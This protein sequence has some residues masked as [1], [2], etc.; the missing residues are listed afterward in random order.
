MASIAVH[1]QA[2]GQGV[3]QA[4]IEMLLE[5]ELERPLYLMCRGRLKTFYEKF[6][7]HAINMEE[8]PPYFQRVSCAERIFNSKAHPDNRLQVM[9]LD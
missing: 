5:S 4:I 1:R 6:G 2:R 3:A 9:R 8:M 7:F